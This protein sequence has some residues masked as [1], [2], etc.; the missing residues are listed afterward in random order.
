MTIANDLITEIMSR[1]PAGADKYLVPA[2]GDGFKLFVHWKLNNDP[3]RPNKYSKTLAIAVP[4]ELIEDFPGYPKQ[5]QQI[6][7]QRIG[8]YIASKLQHFDPDHDTPWGVPD[9]V[10]HWDITIERAFG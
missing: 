2:G 5:M 7:L 8:A 10:V 9:P 6:A 4:R 1:M 3:R